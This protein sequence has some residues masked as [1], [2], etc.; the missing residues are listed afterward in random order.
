MKPIVVKNVALGEGMPK[1]CVPIVARTVSEAREQA[2]EIA[3]LENGIDLVEWR[4]DWLEG[5]VNWDTC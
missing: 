2:L 3:A 4:A 5:F 1:I